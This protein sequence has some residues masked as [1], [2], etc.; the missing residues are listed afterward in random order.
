MGWQD[1]VFCTG[2]ATCAVLDLNQ[3]SIICIFK[4]LKI[5]CV[6]AD[7][8]W[9]LGGSGSKFHVGYVLSQLVIIIV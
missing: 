7:I 8:V 1:Y 3:T 6:H 2:T 4:K 5:R 9:N